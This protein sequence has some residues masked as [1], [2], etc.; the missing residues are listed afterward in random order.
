[1]IKSGNYHCRLA[2]IVDYAFKLAYTSPILLLKSRRYQMRTEIT[3]ID[4]KA[5]QSA[6][7]GNPKASELQLL[8]ELPL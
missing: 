8:N 1:M 7:T 6:T 4:C 5:E 3:H 2:G